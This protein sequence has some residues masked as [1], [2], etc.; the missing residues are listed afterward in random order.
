MKVQFGAFY[1]IIGSRA[2][3]R[4]AVDALAGL[5]EKQVQATGR[6][7]P[8]I[9]YPLIDDTKT[10]TAVTWVLTK[11][12]ARAFRPAYREYENFMEAVGAALDRTHR[13][14]SLAHSPAKNISDIKLP[15]RWMGLM[16][17]LHRLC[18]EKNYL[19]SAQGVL[20]FI[21]AGRFD[22]DKGLDFGPPAGFD[23]K[24]WKSLLGELGFR[25]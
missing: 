11:S 10:D 17:Q 25:K 13:H 16:D 15:R 12:H 3:V 2:E 5:A 18:H 7:V 24:T 14:V 4:Q 23:S 8:F 6:S 9:E 19:L 20:D 1:P 22:L 21:A